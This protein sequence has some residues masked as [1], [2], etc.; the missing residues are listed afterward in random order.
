MN[1]TACANR[2]IVN[3]KLILR[4]GRIAGL[5]KLH[6]SAEQQ[7]EWQEWAVGH[8]AAGRPRVEFRKRRTAELLHIAKREG[9]MKSEDLAKCVA[10]NPVV[11]RRTMGFLWKPGTATSDRGHTRGGVAYHGGPIVR[12][13][14]PVA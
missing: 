1:Y 5:V 8:F 14:V 4:D 11:P 13:A 3:A 7:C 2:R 12:H 9:P 6:R 10:A